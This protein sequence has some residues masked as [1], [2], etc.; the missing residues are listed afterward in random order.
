MKVR[1]L[2][3]AL[4]VALAVFLIVRTKRVGRITAPAAEKKERTLSDLPP[5]AASSLPTTGPAITSP[6]KSINLAI[7]PQ[8]VKKSSARTSPPVAQ[9]QSAPAKKKRELSDPRARVALAYVGVDPDAEGYWLDSI[10][11]TT[12]PDKE[13]EDLMEDLN[14]EGFPDPHHPGPDDL[15][16]ILARLQIIEEVAP[17]AD[18]FMAVHLAEAYKDLANMAAGQAPQ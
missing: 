12:L 4:I 10:F 5:A 13:R 15:P 2:L 16:L 9:S 14:A 8:P 18:E 1:C 7:S 6:E 11:D 3:I 17:W